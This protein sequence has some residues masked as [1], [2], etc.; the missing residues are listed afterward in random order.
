MKVIC[1]K[2]REIEVIKS[3]RKE[4]CCKDLKRAF[5]TIQSDEHGGYG[6]EYT[7]NM[8]VNA[9]IV[10]MI[11]H[12][13]YDTHWDYEQIN[14]CPFC[15]TK[16]VVENIEIDNTG[17]LPKEPPIKTVNMALGRKKHWWN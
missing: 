10:E 1:E 13:N 3:C 16:L 11:I 14:Y 7:S 8:R 4:F 2:R 6:G 17:L 12:A 15:G 9:G 5:E